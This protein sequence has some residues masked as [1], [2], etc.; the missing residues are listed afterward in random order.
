MRVNVHIAY[1]S[2]LMVL[3][4]TMHM[5]GYVHMAINIC[6]ITTTSRRLLHHCRHRRHHQRDLLIRY[7]YTPRPVSMHVST[8]Y[9]TSIYICVYACV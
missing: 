8:G 7:R 4:T 5:H 3:C 1:T 6:V 2:I 9:H